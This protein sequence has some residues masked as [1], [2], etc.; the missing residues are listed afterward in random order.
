[1]SYIGFGKGWIWLGF[2]DFLLCAISGISILQEH[3]IPASEM[4]LVQQHCDVEC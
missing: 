4:G 2:G 1:M 3:G